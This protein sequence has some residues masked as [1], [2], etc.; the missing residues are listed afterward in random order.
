MM[1]KTPISI[2]RPDQ[3]TPRGRELAEL[4]LAECER[5][6]SAPGTRL[7]TERQLAESLGVTRSGVRHALAVL[8]A[9]GRVSR[10]VGRGTFLRSP[11][12]P[13]PDDISPADVM[14]AR[15]LIEPH[16]LPLVIAHATVRDFDEIDRCLAGGAA[17][18]SGEEFEAWDFAFHHAIVAAAHNRLVDRMYA[19]IEAGRQGQLWGTL[20]RRNDSVERRTAYQLDHERIV[21]ALRS[22]EL[23]RAVAASRLHLSRV[24]A[25]LLG[26]AAGEAAGAASPGVD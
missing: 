22:R 4:I 10:E 14:A 11:V 15:E 16:V 13:K 6:G 3:A 7:P 8:E 25:N 2:P 19:A 20:K 1:K 17:A 9:E 18:A 5:A 24:G 26:A 21:D 12:S 23:E